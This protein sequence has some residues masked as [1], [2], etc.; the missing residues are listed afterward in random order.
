MG[1]LSGLRIWRELDLRGRMPWY[2]AVA[3]NLRPAKF[4]IARHIPVAIRLDAPEVELWPEL[5][6]RHRN[7][8]E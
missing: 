7:C 4:R 1:D 5:D 2:R 6:A 8:L 3:D